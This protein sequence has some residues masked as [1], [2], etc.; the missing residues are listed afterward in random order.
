MVMQHTGPL[1]NRIRQRQRF[2]A[3]GRRIA[4]RVALTIFVVIASISAL[5]WARFRPAIMPQAAASISTATSSIVAEQPAWG[6]AM[7]SANA[8]SSVSDGATV[9]KKGKGKARARQQ[10]NQGRSIAQTP[11]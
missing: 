2:S 5:V 8:P 3:R 6:S 9:T 10:R 1:T 7:V 11:R 4:R